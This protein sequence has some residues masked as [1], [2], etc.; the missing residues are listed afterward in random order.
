VETIYLD[1]GYVYCENLFKRVVAPYV[2]I[3]RL[4]GKVISYKVWSSNGAKRKENISLRYFEDNAIDGQRLFGVK[5]STTR[6]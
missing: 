3:A 1:R 5:L 2:D 4:E 6:K